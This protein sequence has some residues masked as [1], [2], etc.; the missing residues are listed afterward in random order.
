MNPMRP[1]FA[2][3]LMAACAVSAAQDCSDIAGDWAGTYS[4]TDCFGDQYAGDWTAV[5]T[6]SCAFTGGSAFETINGTIDPLTG[7]LT[8]SAQ[9][10]EC[11]VVSLTGT[12]QNNI[13]SGTYTY[14]AGGGGSI[15]GDKQIVDT[16]GDGVPDDEDAF[17]TDP[18]ESVDTDGDGI[19][20]NADI[21][22]DG[23]TMPDDYENANG[24]NPLDSSDADGDA[25]G[26]GFTNLQ[27]FRAGTDPQNAADFPAERKVPVAISILLGADEE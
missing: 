2:G 15:S 18:N 10:P 23:D 7:V 19:G 11:G 21:D 14:S 24:L 5:I 9:T 8:A 26:D 17:P 25:D 22:D 16:D 20:N 13:A 12:F 3:V 27:E 1:L 6:S 4:E